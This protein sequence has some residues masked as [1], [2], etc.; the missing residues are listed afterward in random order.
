MKLFRTLV[1]LCIVTAYVVQSKQK[2][3]YFEEHPGYGEDTK[4]SITTSLFQKAF[5]QCSIEDRCRYVIKNL[6]TNEYSKALSE[7]ELPE[8]RGDHKVWYRKD[9]IEPTNIALGKKASQSSVHDYQGKGPFF[10]KFGNDGDKSG[11]Y[12]KCAFTLHDVNPWW[13]VD[14]TKSA[15]VLTVAVK[16]SE[17][18]KPT[19]INPFDIRVG[20]EEKD[21]GRT[22]PHCAKGVTLPVGEMVHFKCPKFTYGR[23]V[24]I[25]L[26]KKEYLIVCEAEVYGII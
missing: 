8:N 19:Q 6:K 7:H 16:S 11:E 9:I 17:T 26:N 13:K 22:N 18:F 24:S 12:Y 25:L 15:L 1:L 21:G 10:A 23:F 2:G 20:A 4:A 14:L 5:H 3:A